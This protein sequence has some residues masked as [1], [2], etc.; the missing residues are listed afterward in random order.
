MSLPAIRRRPMPT[1]APRSTNAEP[2]AATSGWSDRARRPRRRPPVRVLT[3]AFLVPLVAGLLGAPA[4]PTANAGDL[5]DARAAKKSLET[6]IAAQK[7]EIADLNRLQAG[8]RG[9]IGRTTTKLNGINADLTDL[10]KKIGTLRSTIAKVQAKYDEL[11]TQL[12]QLDGAI[13]RLSAREDETRQELSSRKRLLA[14]RIR[15]AYDTEQTSLLETF[16]SSATFTDVLTQVSYQ[17]DAG[18]LD[19]QLA[20]EIEADGVVLASLHETVVET[21]AETDD[22]RVATADQKKQLD[23][24]LRTLDAA[25]KKLRALEAATRKILAA[26][27]AAYAKAQKNKAR[28][29]EALRRSAAAQRRLQK[30]ID[31]IVARQARQGRI[32]SAYN[33]TLRWP[34]SGVV[35][36]NYGCTGFWAEPPLGSCAHFHRGIDIANSYGTPI[37]AAGSGTVVY[38]GWNYAD[39]ADPAFIVIIAHSRTLK[40]WYAHVTPSCPVRAGHHVRAGQTIAHEGMTGHATGP[41]LHWM[42]ERNGSFVNPRLYL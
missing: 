10:R 4:A 14:Q 20:Q 8:L 36:Q 19:R 18:V 17:L 38:C 6:K 25:Q 24:S 2:R 29:R 30:R 31:A 13:D 1:P 16:L 42:V 5:S 27:K 37:H 15:A 39:G 35:T 11:V 26:K 23:A 21:R 3:F 34:M 7:A 41:H 33:G 28:L 12:Q 22:L 40:S 32:P 9:E